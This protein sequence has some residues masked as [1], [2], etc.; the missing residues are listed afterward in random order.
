M[1]P[2]T[3]P[4]TPFYCEENAWHIA[5]HDRLRGRDPQVVF[6]T[7]ARRQ[8]V[9]W[10]QRAARREGTPL[11]WDYH[12]FVV[13]RGDGGEWAVWD[14]DT[15]LGCPIGVG[16]YLEGTFTRTVPAKW[17]PRFRVFSAQEFVA[18][19]SSDR[20]HM[21]D[22]QGHWQAPP[23]AWPA[24]VREGIGSNLESFLDVA[25]GDALDLEAFATRFAS[26]S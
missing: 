14:P 16:A 26:A 24:I 2:E 17:L 19:F 6:V 15:F 9:F 3:L 7:N 20:R 1:R 18:T 21:H 10:N 12:V 5:Q 25:K 11:V 23:P 8:C 22:T 13:A 4:H